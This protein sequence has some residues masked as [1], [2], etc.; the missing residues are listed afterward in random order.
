MAGQLSAHLGPDIVGPLREI[1]DLKRVTDA[2]SP[3]SLATRLFAEGWS[4]LSGG[5]PVGRIAMNLTARA[6]AAARLGGL[7]HQFL[8]AHLPAGVAATD[9]LRRAIDELAEP[10]DADLMSALKDAVDDVPRSSSPQPTFVAQLAAQPR[11]GVTCPGKPRIMLQ[12]EENHADHSFVVAVYAALLAPTYAAD[13][14]EAFFA[15]MVHHL[16]SAAMPDSGF[17]GE[18]LLGDTLVAVID[19]ARAAALAEL[20]PALA[21]RARTAQAMIADDRAP[22]A[23]AFHAAD[24]VDRVLEIRF[25][26]EAASLTMDRVLKSYELVHDGPVKAFHDRVLTEAGLL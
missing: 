1:G 21:D 4:R 26:L 25:H 15:G 3:F 10:F 7:D 14:G 11:A 8:S 5:E 17:T 12:P 20:D 16:H 22:A 18:I 13:S 9:I 2:R 19:S 23:K 24:V 6:L